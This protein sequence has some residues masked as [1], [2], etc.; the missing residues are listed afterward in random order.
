MVLINCYFGDMGSEIDFLSR[1]EDWG[2]NRTY[3]LRNIS[4]Y[5]KKSAVDCTDKLLEQ[6][7]KAIN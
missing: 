3:Y 1:I 5:T 2:K 6:A 4:K 7:Y